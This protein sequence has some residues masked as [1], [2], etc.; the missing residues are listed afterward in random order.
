MLFWVRITHYFERTR[1]GTRVD[2]CYF[3]VGIIGKKV[4]QNSS[5]LKAK[6]AVR[7]RTQTL[8]AWSKSG[9]IQML[10]GRIWLRRPAPNEYG[11][12]GKML[13]SVEG[14][15]LKTPLLLIKSNFSWIG[16]NKSTGDGDLIPRYIWVFLYFEVEGRIHDLWLVF[17]SPKLADVCQRPGTF[18]WK[19]THTGWVISPALLFWPHICTYS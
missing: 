4:T 9:V 2:T 14:K 8:H 15:G 13:T 3:S 18:W 6:K 17:G 11:V 10:R 12:Q 19:L 5:Y 1:N 7:S 16:K